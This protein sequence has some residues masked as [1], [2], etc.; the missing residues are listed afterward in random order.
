[1][2][3]HQRKYDGLEIAVIGISGQFPG[4]PDHR[5]YWKNLCE[6]RELL[7]S[8]S[9]EDLRKSGVSEEAL[10]SGQYVRTVGALENKDFF[11]RGFFGYSTEE[12]AFMDPQIRLYHEHCWKALEDAGYA[13]QIAQKNIGICS[14]A[15][16]NDNWKAH[17]YM[18]SAHAGIDPLYLNMLASRQFISS[19]VAYRLNLKG[20]AYYVDTACS[21]SLVAVHMACRSLL[22][23][24]CEMALAGGISLKCQQQKGYYYKEGL[25]RSADGHCRTFDAAAGGT[26]S[27]EGVGV[28]V[29]KRLADAINDKDHI[30][31]IIKG[32]ATN[33]DGSRKVGFTAPSV[34]GQAE[35]IS[36]ALKVAHTPAESISYVEAHGTATR[37]G[38]PIEIKA[39]N[40]AFVAGGDRKFCAIGS[41]KTNMGHLDAAAGI[42]GFIKTV[43]ALHYR[44]LPPSLHFTKP[45]PEIEF[46][47][48]PFFVNTALRT[49]T[50]ANG[51]RFAQVSAHL[52]WGAPM[53]M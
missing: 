38:D 49:W 11:D 30:Y 7:T 53:H 5:A 41:V 9:D 27:G 48:G 8:F 29:L 20:P 40:E 52:E 6:G 45:N 22:T 36:K 24:E 1:M 2:A 34:Q 28:V 17:T 35:C 25:I 31:A 12:T 19:L 21:S 3:Q 23:R 18:Q 33:N 51:A 44:Q 43:L 4:S 46:D 14:A 13:S 10:Q 32:S 47:G 50:A 15:S 26:T 39:L 37:L 16:E 42:A